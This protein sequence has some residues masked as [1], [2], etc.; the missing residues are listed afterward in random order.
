MK[1][2]DIKRNL[3]KFN[4]ERLVS[5]YRSGSLNKTKQKIAG[6]I[7]TRRGFTV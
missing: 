5:K 2:A 3:T 4:S 7:L 1:V 6:E